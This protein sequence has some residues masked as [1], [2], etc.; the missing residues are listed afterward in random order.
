MFD[1]LKNSFKFK[2]SQEPLISV[3]KEG[4][5]S[6]KRQVSIGLTPE[7]QDLVIK[8]FCIGCRLA[9]SMVSLTGGMGTHPDLLNVD[10]EI[11]V[12]REFAKHLVS[13]SMAL[14]AYWKKVRRTGK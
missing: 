14:G 12:F 10:V 8:C 5:F 1:F 4:T 7:Q 9:I 3:G 11:L 2:K 13:M 6:N